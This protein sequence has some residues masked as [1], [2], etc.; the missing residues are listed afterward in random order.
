MKY[1]FLKIKEFIAKL[2]NILQ[3]KESQ[4]YVLS[5]KINTSGV[6]YP[7]K[8]V[9]IDRKTGN[10]VKRNGVV[11]FFKTVDEAEKEAQKLNHL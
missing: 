2:R 1:I 6:K 5:S 9:I 4:F 11:H 7:G 10:Y 8:I 3:K